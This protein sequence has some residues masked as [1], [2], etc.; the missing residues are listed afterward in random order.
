MYVVGVPLA[1][2][3]GDTLPHGGVS[4]VTDQTTPPL[5][6]SFVTVAMN[7]AVFPVET[8]AGF[9]VTEMVNP[10]TVIAAD[11]PTPPLETA[12][13]SN[14]TP[15]SPNGS[16]AGGVYVVGA[17]LAVV[18]GETDPQGPLALQLTDQVT[19]P[20]AGSLATVALTLSVE[21]T[22]TVAFCG[23]TVIAIGA[24]FTTS[25][26]DLLVSATDVAKIVTA[27]APAGAPGAV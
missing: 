3:V 17:P 7:G 24:T 22:A 13:A 26:A 2:D 12:V 25:E 14:V 10:G 19:P 1:V 16:V 18:L 9:G 4:Q 8:V 6:A 11:A 21:P 23:V 20:F 27:K 15:R 5:L